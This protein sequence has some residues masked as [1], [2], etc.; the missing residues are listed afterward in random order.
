MFAVS[1]ETYLTSLIE[2]VKK[3]WT[4]LDLKKWSESVG[5][6]SS[7]AVQA[8]VYFSLSLAVGFLFKKYFR[9]LFACLIITAFMLKACESANFITIDWIAIKTY[10]GVTPA[11]DFTAVT[12]AWFAWIRSNL[13]IFVSSV[14][15]F[16]VGYKLG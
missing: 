11:T 9:I 14:V 15:G 3:F 8:A 13:L 7:E 10:F 16:M 1:L 2:N 6:S 5:G 4:E 12:N